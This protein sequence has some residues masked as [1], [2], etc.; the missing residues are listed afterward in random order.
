MSEACT[1][2][3]IQ[4]SLGENGICFGQFFGKS[5]NF[6]IMVNR[7]GIRRTI[8][9]QT[10]RENKQWMIKGIVQNVVLSLKTTLGPVSHKRGLHICVTTWG[11]DP[12]KKG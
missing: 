11:P 12:H 9:A 1:F 7:Q 6:M 4:Q 2:W 3:E 5:E 10:G 8:K